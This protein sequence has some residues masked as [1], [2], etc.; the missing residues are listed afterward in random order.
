[1]AAIRWTLRRVG[2]D[3]EPAADFLIA[4][5]PIERVEDLLRAVGPGAVRRP[6]SVN[7]RMGIATLRPILNQGRYKIRYNRPPLSFWRAL[8]I[9]GSD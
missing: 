1:M 3:L 8:K 6:G 9:S 4:R 5:R 7:S 2:Q